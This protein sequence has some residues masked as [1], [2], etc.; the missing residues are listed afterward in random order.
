MTFTFNIISISTHTNYKNL[1]ET[2]KWFWCQFSCH[3]LWKVTD[4]VS[5]FSDITVTGSQLYISRD[6]LT[7]REKRRPQVCFYHRNIPLTCA[8][9]ALW[10]WYLSYQPSIHKPSL[11]TRLPLLCHRHLCWVIFEF[12]CFTY[13]FL[14]YKVFKILFV[15]YDV[16]MV[17]FFIKE[18][19]NL[20]LLLVCFIILF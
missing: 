16:S 9:G 11:H 1:V 13:N 3:I 2:Q 6:E 12:S 5:T 17:M 7:C 8:A 14:L 4:P 15:L 10:L 19:E 20:F 18:E